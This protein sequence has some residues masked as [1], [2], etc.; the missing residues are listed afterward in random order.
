MRVPLIIDPR[1]DPHPTK[2]GLS[3]GG[4][5]R[6][7]SDTGNLTLSG[8]VPDPR[9]VSIDNITIV[10]RLGSTV[11][12]DTPCVLQIKRGGIVDRGRG[13][14][15]K[16]CIA[17]NV[18]VKIGD[19][20]VEY[21]DVI[22][23][24]RQ[25]EERDGKVTFTEVPV[26]FVGICV[27]RDYNTQEIRVPYSELSAINFVFRWIDCTA[28]PIEFVTASITDGM[29]LLEQS[30][31]AR[32]PETNI[33][34]INTM[35]KGGAMFASPYINYCM[36]LGGIIGT[37][38]YSYTECLSGIFKTTRKV[39]NQLK[40][41]DFFLPPI[42]TQRLCFPDDW[43]AT[44]Q[45]PALLNDTILDS[46]TAKVK[47]TQAFSPPP[48][49]ESPLTESDEEGAR[50]L[51][52]INKRHREEEQTQAPSTVKRPTKIRL[53]PRVPEQPMFLEM[54]PHEHAIPVPRP[55]FLPYPQLARQFVPPWSN[56]GN[57]IAPSPVRPTSVVERAA[58]AVATQTHVQIFTKDKMIYGF[59]INNG[60]VFHLNAPSQCVSYTEGQ[61]STTIQIV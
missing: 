9:H 50:I 34:K 12:A 35:I 39:D 23:I 2:G 61:G 48:V 44:L 11:D 55:S 1:G 8:G 32:D 10:K 14:G 30:P 51:D 37:S 17:W 33:S 27:S 36:T 31:F 52:S 59:S 47:H 18:L 19:I 40:S 5:T 60:P 15:K 4:I 6:T 54:P 58:S 21:G 13:K 57:Y 45:W 49:G 43:D 28:K 7:F 3:P 26:I 42:S 53:S 41:A 24:E 29:T 25:L 38:R 22:F 20:T 46:F 16:V 56:T